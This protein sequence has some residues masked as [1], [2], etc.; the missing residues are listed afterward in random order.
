[1]GRSRLSHHLATRCIRRPLESHNELHHDG[2]RLWG[3]SQNYSSV[4]FTSGFIVFCIEPNT[5][6]VEF[7]LPEISYR[8]G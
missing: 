6:Q 3:A 7:M 4:L 5:S 1:M 2:K 8:K